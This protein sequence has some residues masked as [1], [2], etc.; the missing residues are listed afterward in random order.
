MSHDNNHAHHII[1]FAVL[2]KTFIALV[3][4]TILTVVCARIH[5]GMFEAPVALL[6]AIAKAFLVISFF[7]GLKYDA[8]SNRIIFASA[9]LFLFIFAFFTALDIWTRIAQVSTL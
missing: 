7:M 9:Y 3:F 6:I 2:T 5:L 1:P 8:V 4:L